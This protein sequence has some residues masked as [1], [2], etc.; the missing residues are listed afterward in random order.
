MYDLTHI[1]GLRIQYY[2]KNW[3]YT[4]EKLSQL[5][6]VHPSY[7]GQVE[8]GEKNITIKS[9]QRITNALDVPLSSLFIGIDQKASD[10]K[11]IPMLCYH[12]IFSKSLEDQM[13]L[14]RILR[15]IDRKW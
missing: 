2:R 7:I 6:D 4:Q 13:Y 12:L 8:R 14:Y 15:D 9:L 1:V 3:G 5:S 11:D 10:E